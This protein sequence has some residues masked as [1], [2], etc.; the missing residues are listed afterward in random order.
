MTRRKVPLPDAILRIV[1]VT[2]GNDKVDGEA[3]AL[4][5]SGLRQVRAVAEVIRRQLDGRRPV[6]LLAA[7]PVE[8]N[9]ETA[10]VLAR[11]F[12][13][14]FDR[15][16]PPAVSPHLSPLDE[17][18]LAYLCQEYRPDECLFIVVVDNLTVVHTQ[19]TR[20]NFTTGDVSPASAHLFEVRTGEGLLLVSNAPLS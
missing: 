4:T 1:L 18:V 3:R 9:A 10:E 14:T 2:R 16:L 11:A 12:G 6:V 13:T 20:G 15:D 7:S 17:P 8:S 5:R 19:V